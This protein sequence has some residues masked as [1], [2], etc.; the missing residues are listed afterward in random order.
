MGV[1]CAAW[2]SQHACVSATEVF[3]AD[4]ALPLND[5]LSWEG[6]L[7]PGPQDIAVFDQRVT[8]SRL[9]FVL[10]ADA[11]WGGV[12][13]TNS[14]APATSG[15]VT[16]GTNG[17]DA[18]TLTLGTNG[19]CLGGSGLALT[20]SL[21]LVLSDAQTW[22]LDRRNLTFNG[23]VSGAADWILST[24]SQVTWNVA[25]GYGGNLI[26]SNSVFTQ[27]FNKAGRWAKSL[28][29]KNSSSTRLEMA[30]TSPNS[31]SDLF[32]DRT[33]TVST[34]SG[35]TSGGT[36]TFA[37]GDS[38]NFGGS[39]FV[40]D[41]GTGVQNGGALKGGT[42]QSGYTDNNVCYTMNGGTMS[43]SSGLVLGN[44]LTRLDREAKFRQTG[45]TVEAQSVQAGWASCKYTGVP[46]YE[47][48]GGVLRITGTSGADTGIHLSWNA[49]NWGYGNENSGAFLMQGGRVETDQIALGRSDTNAVYAITNAFS[50]F[51]M[52]GGELVL[53]TRGFYAGRSWN[54]GGA[55]SGYVV[56]LL[57]GTLTAG[58][59]WSSTLDL[60]LDDANGGTAFNT[61]NTNG[62]AQTVLMKGALYGPGQ[63]IKRGAGVL[64]LAGEAAYAGKTTVEAGTLVVGTSAPTDCYLWTAD[65]L[66]GTNNSPVMT[67]ADQNM[68]ASATN[69]AVD[70]APRLVLGEINGHSAVRFS[71]AAFQHLA[72]PAASSP[73]SGATAFSIAV[74]FK[75]GTA[76]Y[77]GSGAW[78]A[79]TG[80][81]DAEQGGVVS[82]WGLVY[83]SSGWVGGGAGYPAINQDY[84]VWSA[85]GYSVVDNLPHVAIY[86]WQGTNMLMNVDGRVTTRVSTSP[87][88]AARNTCRMLFGSVA[89]EG[90]KYFN[91]DM[92]EI[93]VYRN[94]ALTEDEQNR[95][96]NDLALTYGVANSQFATP[97]GE[98]AAAAGG[99]AAATPPEAPAPL[100]Y[101]S[102]VWDADTLSGAA[103]SAVSTW[104]A[105][106]G[107]NTASQSAAGTG[108]APVFAPG[109]LNGHHAVHFTGSSSS[110][111]GIPAGHNPVSG[112][113]N[114]TVALVFRTAT[115]GYFGSNQQWW[116]CAGL[117]DA[118]Q[119]DKQNDWGICFTRDGRV[120]GGIGKEDVTVFSKPFDLCDGQPHVAVFSCN[121][122]GGLVTVMLD[123]LA[124]PKAMTA[125]TSPRNAYR[126]LLGSLNA[127]T[128]F[129]GD[130]ATFRF[131]PECA[132]TVAEMTSLSTELAQKYGIRFVPRGNTFLPKVTGVGG[133]DVEVRSGAALVLP[134]ATNAP[135][136][137]ASGQT[138]FGGGT[139]RGTL[140]VATN[141]VVDI[142]ASETLRMGDLWLRD[143]ATLRWNHSGGVG[144]ALTV[145]S[146][147]TA[148]SAT[149]E[150]VG[151]ADLPVRVPVVRYQ[152]GEG[153][154]GTVW[155]VTGGAHNSRVEINAAAKTLDLVT[156]KGT[157]I[158]VR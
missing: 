97:T 142:G 59:S 158:F 48:T 20:M 122:T 132:L 54:N 22:L 123:G 134:E 12:A 94:R 77:G 92:A 24:S 113:T 9:S 44:G 144:G 35:L 151:G 109:A 153:L 137:L 46:T 40:F 63:L 67:W 51:K 49:Y 141:A 53:G 111:L 28:T 1:L 82:D 106:N 96:G 37:D 81:V 11:A 17:A 127:G 110:V 126:V 7:A 27:K 105:T 71:S 129:T 6:G 52:T 91:G 66:A 70:K 4:N 8:A 124:A 23:T 32:A 74:V 116:E 114:F 47:M 10:T 119:P 89:L 65:S 56:K 76:G 139:V 148:G 16:F 42:F 57:G 34:W 21:P 125:H 104:V 85:S 13:I 117:I 101:P 130:L 138:I 62:I 157:A 25:S 78:Y 2:V 98:V 30:F 14:A 128:F 29:I 120:G 149:L 60:Y 75:T 103:G 88:V 154:E 86:T 58:A 68:G 133:G 31:W 152:S 79:N 61:Q 5:P 107:V 83:N 99:I 115:P 73:V 136:T 146:L 38:Y 87:V 150:V 112:V 43:L 131:Y 41:N 19:V 102:V 33:A 80:L 147:K 3:K 121:A 36:L 95:I 155:T 118:E 15:T 100:A 18:A 45:G 55:E 93:R 64:T 69:T 135:L 140:A 50:L 145:A 108:V 39:Q 72:V 84:T 26:V 156:A 90:N 143:G